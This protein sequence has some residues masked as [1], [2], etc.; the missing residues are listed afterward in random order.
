MLVWWAIRRQISNFARN[1][2]IDCTASFCL[3]AL[4]TN[5]NFPQIITVIIP[6][7]FYRRRG[8]VQLFFFSAVSCRREEPITSVVTIKWEAGISIK[9]TKTCANLA[10][11]GFVRQIGRPEDSG[12]RATSGEWLHRQQYALHLDTSGMRFE[13]RKAESKHRTSKK[14]GKQE[15]SIPT[16]YAP[17]RARLR[18]RDAVGW[19]L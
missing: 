15:Q 6:G 2:T 14:Q 4:R 10:G 16:V 5:I 8:R 1:A 13:I 11:V 18:G 3:L 9:Q 17:V 12:L 19:I 7:F